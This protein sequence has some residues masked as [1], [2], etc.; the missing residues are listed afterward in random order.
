[1]NRLQVIGRLGRDPELKQTSHGLVATL[2][3]ATNEYGRDKKVHTEWHD[4]VLFDPLSATARDYL[5]KG[6]EIF[7]EG[8]MHTRKWTD[9][10]GRQ[11]VDKD[12]RVD[13]LRILRVP[14]ADLVGQPLE[15]LGSI[16]SVLRQM[17]AGTLTNATS[18]D[19]ANM[20]AT[21]R[22]LLTEGK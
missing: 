15:L 17:H 2:S 8:R 21:V 18:E 11:R 10:E 20:I 19:V 13:A 5:R 7:A 1:M 14:R 6:V 22:E 12:M 9:A 3:V 16:E 4:L